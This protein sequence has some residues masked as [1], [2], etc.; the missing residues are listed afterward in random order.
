VTKGRLAFREGVRYPLS[1]MKGFAWLG[2]AALV[3]AFAVA[4]ACG[5]STTSHP[6]A[7]DAGADASVDAGGDAGNQCKACTTDAQCGSGAICAQLGS[8]MYCATSCDTSSQCASGATC[9]PVNDATGAQEG[10]CVPRGG[11]CGETLGDA[12]APDAPAMCG[13]LVGP[14][15]KAGCQCPSGRTC[16]AN[17]CRYGDY[18][19]T[20]TSICQPAPIGCGT[21]GATYDGG[22]PP[23]GTVGV[24][25]GALSRLYFG[26]VGDTRPPDEDDTSGYPTAIITKIFAD[27]QALS[28]RPSF[29]VSTGD[30]QYANPTGTQGAIQVGYYLMAR[31]GY[32]GLQ[33]PAMGNHECTGLTNSNCGEGNPDGITNNYTTFMQMLLA[34]IGQTSPYYEMDVDAPD[35]S[36]TAKFLFIAANAWTQTQADWLAAAMARAT[37]Y[38]FLV[39]HESASADTAPGVNPSENI[40]AMHPYT[41]SIVGHTHTYQ[42]SAAR[43]IIIGNGGA[44]LSGG[45]DYGYGMLSQQSDG[46][47]AVDVIDYTSGLADPSFHFAVNPDGSPA[48]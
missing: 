7:A 23:T 9:T 37:T 19:D 41:L 32:S 36:W 35:Q 33:F 6:A 48:Q 30:Y 28:P 45:V 47:I 38:T 1:T 17:G 31:A 3:A 42:H 2:A 10:A 26:V 22:A 4:A 40:M 14:N 39:R 21:P 46:T 16:T 44:P 12:G 5:G 13:T 43:E 8:A 24:D 18:C 34:P 20:T 29:V 11:E 15:V 27:I 25:G